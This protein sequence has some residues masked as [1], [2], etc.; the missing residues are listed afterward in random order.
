MAGRAKLREVFAG[1][2]RKAFRAGRFLTLPVLANAG[3]MVYFFFD[4]FI[5]LFASSISPSPS[6]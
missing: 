2:I 1:L 3:E 4:H 6:G 5:W